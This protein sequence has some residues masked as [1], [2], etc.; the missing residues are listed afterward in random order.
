MPSYANIVLQLNTERLSAAKHNII[1]L[2]SEAMAW[3][4]LRVVNI[5]VLVLLPIASA[6]LFICHIAMGI[7]DT[8]H[9]FGNI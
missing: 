6:I 2:Y 1:S 3:H 5:A 4:D 7:G 9:F 8:F